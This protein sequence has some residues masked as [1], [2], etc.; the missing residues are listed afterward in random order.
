MLH[1]SWQNRSP[2]Y[3]DTDLTF[4]GRVIAKRQGTEGNVV[5]LEVWE[6]NA[7]GRVLMPG[8]AVVALPG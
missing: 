5:E 2:A 7:E 8:T 4:R 6:E 3:P 1:L